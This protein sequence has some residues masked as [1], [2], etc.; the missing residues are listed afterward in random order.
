MGRHRW[1]DKMGGACLAAGALLWSTDI[2]AQDVATAEALFRRGLKD[3]DAGDY[4]SGC[5][6]IAESLR[7]DPRAGTLFTLAECEAGAGKVATAVARYQDY[8]ELYARMSPPQQSKQLGREKIAADKKR[9]LEPQLPMLTIVLPAAAPTGVTVRRDGTELA[10]PALSTPLPVDPG[11]HVIQVTYPN[12]ALVEKRVTVTPGQQLTVELEANVAPPETKPTATSAVSAAPTTAPTAS[13]GVPGES[14]TSGRRIATYALGGVGVAGLVLGAVAGG[15]V[16][17]K[18][19]TIEENC[20]DID[21]NK[22]GKDAADSAKTLALVSTIGFAA[23]V[24]AFA[25]S[26]ALFF[27]EPREKKPA[28]KGVQLRP[29]VVASDSGVH[30]SLSG[31]W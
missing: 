2:A 1:F 29:V 9:A 12:G 7:L 18:K 8:L 27:T 21:C 10:R 20:A 5:P 4:K 26:A 6:A 16:F 24:G 17:E 28:Q 3:M 22:T 14:G 31:R 11:E 19:S 23:G 30:L 15:L 25:G 13:S